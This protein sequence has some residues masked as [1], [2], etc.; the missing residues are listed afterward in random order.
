MSVIVYIKIRQREREAPAAVATPKLPRH[1]CTYFTRSFHHSR[2]QSFTKI[3]SIIQIRFN[4]NYKLIYDFKL[5]VINILE[6]EKN[7]IPYGS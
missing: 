4:D 6:S 2:I 1:S 5:L 3:E 7:R